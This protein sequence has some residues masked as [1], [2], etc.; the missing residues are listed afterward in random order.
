[1]STAFEPWMKCLSE[2]WRD[3]RLH[4]EVV[5]AGVLDRLPYIPS[6]VRNTWLDTCENPTAIRSC[7]HMKRLLSDHRTFPERVIVHRI[8]YNLLW[9]SGGLKA[10]RDQCID[11]PSNGD[12]LCLKWIQQCCPSTQTSPYS[13]GVNMDVG[14]LQF[15]CVAMEGDAPGADLMKKM[16]HFRC[17]F[18][19][20]SPLLDFH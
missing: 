7:Y 20:F 4:F 10:N 17:H 11:G 6:P 12:E 19:N 13:C 1:M 18:F 3:E 8:V 5:S 9:S 14:K 15:I 16:L 2:C